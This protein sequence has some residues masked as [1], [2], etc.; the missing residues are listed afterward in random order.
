MKLSIHAADVVTVV[1]YLLL[2]VATGI[3]F[4]RRNRTTEDYFVGNRSF[5][6]WVIGLSMLGTI[7]SSATFLA[8]PAVHIFSTGGS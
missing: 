4:S 7:V 2:M 3:Y 1:I 8:L 5:S 6:G